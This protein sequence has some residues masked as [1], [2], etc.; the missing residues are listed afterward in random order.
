[1]ED[2]HTS[3]GASR[4]KPVLADSPV[5][6]FTYLASLAY[7]VTGGLSQHPATAAVTPMQRALASQVEAISFNRRTAALIKRGITAKPDAGEE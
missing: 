4:E 5:D 7:L 2:L 6:A 1:M 3:F